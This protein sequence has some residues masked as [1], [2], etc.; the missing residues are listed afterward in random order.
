MNVEVFYFKGCPHAA[1][2]LALVRACAERLGIAV[3]IMERDGDF[4]SPSVRV[5]GRDVMGEP[6]A[7]GRACRC[8]LPTE[9]RIAAALLEAST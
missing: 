7:S 8:D 4:P 9:E 2:A 6:G 1:S 3:A 5:N